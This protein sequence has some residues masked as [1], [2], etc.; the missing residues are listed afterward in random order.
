MTKQQKAKSQAL[1]KAQQKQANAE[2][3][4]AVLAAWQV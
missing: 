1:K 3:Q 2:A 4:G